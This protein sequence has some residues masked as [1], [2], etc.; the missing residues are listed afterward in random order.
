MQTAD[1]CKVFNTG[2]TGFTQTTGLTVQEETPDPCCE[3]RTLVPTDD[4][5]TERKRLSDVST[6]R[7]LI[8][9]EYRLFSTL[10]HRSQS[11]HS[12]LSTRRPGLRCG[13]VPRNMP[14]RELLRTL[15]DFVSG[16]VGGERAR[17]GRLQLS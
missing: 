1:C 4:V 8:V 11:D 2:R 16:L 13:N 12:S 9:L 14:T 15:L 10:S 3:A 7:R 5:N 6:H 17:R